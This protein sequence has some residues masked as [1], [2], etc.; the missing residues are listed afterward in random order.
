MNHGAER[1]TP[2]GDEVRRELRWLRAVTDDD[3]EQGASLEEVDPN[4]LASMNI[5]VAG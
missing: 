4:L 1:L 5:L 3:D 2:D